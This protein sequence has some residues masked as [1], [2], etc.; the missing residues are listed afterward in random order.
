MAVPTWVTE[1]GVV[2]TWV[3]GF[4]ALFGERIRTWCFRPKLHLEPDH[5]GQQY[6]EHECGLTDREYR[7]AILTNGVLT[8]HTA[9]VFQPLLARYKGA[10]G[11][12][13][14]GK[15]HVITSIISRCAPRSYTLSISCIQGQIRLRRH[16]VIGSQGRWPFSGVA[17]PLVAGE[18]PGAIR[19]I[20]TDVGLPHG[21]HRP[22]MSP[23]IRS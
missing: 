9:H 4:I 11:G 18:R 10:W 6:P 23:P 3:V 20:V 7:A 2:G 21:A 14:S 15:S 13:G 1:A 8:I 12:R 19:D 17:T 5:P 22:F 16:L